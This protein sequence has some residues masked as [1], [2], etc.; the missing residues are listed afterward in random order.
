M[1][2]PFG[3]G[4]QRGARSFRYTHQDGV[5]ETDHGPRRVPLATRSAVPTR[6]ARPGY[7]RLAREDPVKKKLTLSKET[8]RTLDEQ[9]LSM[10]VGGDQSGGNHPK[11]PNT[12][13]KSCGCGSNGA[14]CH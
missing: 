2:L 1:I 10:V 6:S 12:K 4:D 7:S 11:C 14:V 5:D 9:E 8:L 13:D 3:G